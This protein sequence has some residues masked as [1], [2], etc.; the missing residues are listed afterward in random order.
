MDN[1]IS[2]SLSDYTGKQ[3]SFTG[4]R[5]FMEFCV[6]ERDYWKEQSKRLNGVAQST[7]ISSHGTFE[8]IINTIEG[9]GDSIKDWDENTF[10]NQF[11]QQ[12]QRNHINNLPN[13]WLWSGHPFNE[14][15]LQCNKDKGKAAADVFINLVA[16]NQF[17]TINNLDT[18]QGSMLAY[19]FLNQKS[20]I[21]KRR[22][23]EKTSLGH[24]R[25]Q[26]SDAKTKLFSEIEEI[27]SEYEDWNTKTRQKA[28]Q[29]DRVSK[30]LRERRESRND[31]SFNEQLREWSSTIDEL[32]R[33]YEEKLRLAKPAE[34]WNKA[35]SKYRIQGAL[36]IFFIFV[37]VAVGLL[38]FREFFIVWLQGKEIGIELNTVKGIILFGTILAVYA[39]LLRILSRLTFSSFHLMRDAE[40]REQLTYLYLSLSKETEVDKDSRDIVLQALFSRTETGLLSQE[41]GPTMP[42]ATDMIKSALHRRG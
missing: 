2:V 33:T 6:Q 15:Y 37:L 40:E 12:V 31:N 20:E 35:A 7:F 39:Y 32:E 34:Y 23:G 24:L 19:E 42:T 17:T 1:K 10:N 5:E 36:G 9:W 11:A 28:K 29:L 22:N 4:L 41:H 26:L 18:L 8:S 13:L 14:N 38:Y 25:N 30:K 16:K 3:W 27:K 21:T